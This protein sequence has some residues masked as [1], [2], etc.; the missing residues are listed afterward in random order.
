MNWKEIKAEK[1]PF[2]IIIHLAL[3][4]R[5]L[6]VISVFFTLYLQLNFDHFGN[7]SHSLDDY[8]ILLLVEN[9]ILKV[10]LL[11]MPC[12]TNWIWHVPFFCFISFST[13]LHE[14]L[15]Y[16][17]CVVVCSFFF[18]CF[19]SRKDLFQHILSG[20]SSIDIFCS[21][22]QYICFVFFFAVL[23]TCVFKTQH[24]FEFFAFHVCQTL[25]IVTD[26]MV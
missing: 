9:W 15:K 3:L 17:I 2:K 6:N 8:E 4:N 13:Y 11:Q 25:K 20:F 12:V 19:P 24:I 21:L 5:V 26:Y 14:M 22:F 10:C 23:S 18:I 7:L 1:N 16:H